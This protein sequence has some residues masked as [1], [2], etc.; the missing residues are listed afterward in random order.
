[1]SQRYIREL[2][3]G[4]CYAWIWT[5]VYNSHGGLSLCLHASAN[6]DAYI[7]NLHAQSR[8]TVFTIMGICIVQVCVHS[9]CLFHGTFKYCYFLNKCAPLKWPYNSHF[10]EFNDENECKLKPATRA[11]FCNFFTEIGAVVQKLWYFEWDT[12][13]S[14]KILSC[15]CTQNGHHCDLRKNTQFKIFLAESVS[16]QTKGASV[17]TI[18]DIIFC[19]WAV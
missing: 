4:H 15:I 6:L 18:K 16:I 8:A 13:H 11:T 14:V 1:M 12:S 17:N 5:G 7:L 9:W 10:W 19:F 2:C 3:V